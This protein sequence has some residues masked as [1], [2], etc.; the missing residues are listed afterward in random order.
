MKIAHF[1]PVMLLSLLPAAPACSQEELPAEQAETAAM[2]ASEVG[3][4]QL[5]DAQ[6][7]VT[8]PKGAEPS[9][10]QLFKLDTATGSVWIGKQ[11][12]YIDKRTGR[13]VQQ[14]YWEPFE[15]YLEGPAAT[16]VK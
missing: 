15:Q 10:K 11:V 2:P 5:F 8:S 16:P 7:T 6:Y 9:E 12:Q 13:L 3:R 14:R 4:Y 1:L